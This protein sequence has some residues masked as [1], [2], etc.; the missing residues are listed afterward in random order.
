M[1]SGGGAPSLGQGAP[2]GVRRRSHALQLL[3]VLLPTALLVVSLRR[4]ARQRVGARVRCSEPSAS[5]PTPISV[6]LGHGRSI[7]VP[8][9]RGRS[10]P[11]S[12]RPPPALSKPRS[13]ELRRTGAASDSSMISDGRSS[14]PDRKELGAARAPGR[15]SS[16]LDESPMRRRLRRGVGRQQLKID[17]KLARQRTKN[18]QTGLSRS[19]VSAP[20]PGSGRG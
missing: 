3:L 15:S 8:T 5:T 20:P 17:T 1:S 12:Q 13:R 18:K 9:R 4:A 2:A 16:S 19:A 6:A 11:P 10:Q 7:S 14:G